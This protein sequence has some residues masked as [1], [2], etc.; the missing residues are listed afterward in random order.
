MRRT[1]LVSWATDR[2][3]AKTSVYI[4]AE[5][6]DQACLIAYDNWGVR[7]TVEGVGREIEEPSCTE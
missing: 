6:A 2:P 1:Y 3:W 7:G 4:A 5:D